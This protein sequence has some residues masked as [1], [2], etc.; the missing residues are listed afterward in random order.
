MHACARRLCHDGSREPCKPEGTTSFLDLLGRLGSTVYG[1]HS[2]IEEVPSS[3]ANAQ[4]LLSVGD[5]LDELI[6]RTVRLVV[7]FGIKVVNVVAHVASAMEDILCESH[8]IS[9][10]AAVLVSPSDGGFGEISESGEE[11]H[12]IKNGTSEKVTQC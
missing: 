5:R 6:H 4:H 2:V 11:T 10:P 9:G 8:G 12:F 7:E 3:L 1:I